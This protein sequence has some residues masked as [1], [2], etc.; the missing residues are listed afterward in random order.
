LVS[1]LVL[2]DLWLVDRTLIEGRRESEV[3]GDSPIVLTLLESKQELPFRVYSPSY[4]IPR[5]IGAIYGIECADG[6]DPLYLRDYDI[7]MQTASGVLRSRYEVTIPAMEGEEE[8]AVVNREAIPNLKLLGFLNVKYLASEFP[9]MQEGLK[10]AGSWSG[11]W[12]Y[13]NNHYLPRAYLVSQ[14]IRVDDLQQALEYLPIIDPEHLA[15]VES[16]SVFHLDDLDGG[17][18]DLLENTPNRIVYR[19]VSQ[20]SAF[21][22]LSQVY[23]P[24]WIATVNNQPVDI[25]KTNGVLSGVSLA[26]GENV[27]EFVYRP[28]LTWLSGGISLLAIAWLLI[29][30]MVNTPCTFTRWLF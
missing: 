27:V 18:V 5:Q 26:A 16:D 11:T 9:L 6:V 22:V 13:E 17:T 3:F 21:L 10:E 14:V 1:I 2:A 12:L 15:V 25:I 30:V 20:G 8:V 23:Y 24:G 4:S 28:W 29:A 7:F 19:V